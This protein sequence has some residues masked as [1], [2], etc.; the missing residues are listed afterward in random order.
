MPAAT[1]WRMRDIIRWRCKIGS[2]T[3]RSSTRCATPSCRQLGSRT[4][5]ESDG[6]T[7]TLDFARAPRGAY[8]RFCASCG[9]SHDCLATVT[10]LSCR[11]AVIRT[12]KVPSP[13]PPVKPLPIASLGFVFPT[14]RGS[15]P[16]QRGERECCLCGVARGR[17]DPL[18]VEIVSFGPPNPGSTEIASTQITFESGRCLA[19]RPLFCRPLFRITR[20]AR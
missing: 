11:Q 17:S 9:R 3:A 2:A 19:T 1:L 12:A 20:F 14:T 8:T 15:Q 7:V 10:R 5:G 6:G 16:S 18:M 4:S 13:D